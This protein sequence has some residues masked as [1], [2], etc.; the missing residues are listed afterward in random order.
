MIRNAPP[1]WEPKILAPRDVRL[2]MQKQ[3]AERHAQIM[4]RLPSKA[5]ISVAIDCWTSPNHH[6]FLAIT[7]YISRSF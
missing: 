1:S 2:L 6:S 5:K 4:A 7:G 3:V